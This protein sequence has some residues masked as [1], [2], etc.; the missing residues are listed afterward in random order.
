MGYFGKIEEKIKAQEL[1]K[2]G[3]SYKEILTKIHVSKDTI[4]RWCRDIVLTESQ[5]N[6]LIE[7]K[8]LGQK[9]GSI[10][11]AENKKKLRFQ[12]IKQINIISKK[13]LGKIKNRD[14]FIAGIALYAGEG[15]KT[16]GLIG[17]SN[18]NPI[19]IKFM[20]KWFKSFCEIPIKK[21]KG[22]IWLHEGLD[23]DKAITFWSELTKIPKT[24]FYKTY[25]AQVKSNS[26]KIRKNI[27][28]YGVFAIR[29]SNSEIHRKIIG[30]N[31]AL[32]NAKIRKAH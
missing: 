2:K 3:L 8:K 30:W 22:A 17:F 16:N 6:R 23:K 21:I 5:K 11:A 12:M 14:N 18:S 32:F 7:N 19:L 29:I 20:V 27:H 26:N 9:K 28:P 13:E 31:N 10:I 15:N 24:N 1:R 4:S 25:I